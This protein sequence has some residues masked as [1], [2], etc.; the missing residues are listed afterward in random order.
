MSSRHARPR[1]TSHPPASGRGHAANG[2]TAMGPRGPEDPARR[3]WGIP[4]PVQTRQCRPLLPTRP[5]GRGALHFSRGTVRGQRAG[6]AAG[7]PRGS[8]QGQAACGADS[9]G[10]CGTQGGC[11]STSYFHR[12]SGHLGKACA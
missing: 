3:A 4:T 2:H 8:G 10:G 9:K 6:P 5:L 12:S 1:H 11:R 7:S